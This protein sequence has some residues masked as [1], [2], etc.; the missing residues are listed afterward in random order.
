MSSTIDRVRGVSGVAVVLIS[1]HAAPAHALLFEEHDHGGHRILL[2]RDC[3]SFVGDW[4]KRGDSF[5][6]RCEPWQQTFSYR[7]S[8]EARDGRERHYV[9]DPAQ[10]DALLRRN[11]YAEVWLL[12]GG[13][14]LQAG[15]EMGRMFRQ[16]QMTV[17]VPSAGRIQAAVPGARLFRQGYCVSACTVA[18]MGGLFRLVDE[19]AT[20]EVHSAST[21]QQD[22]PAATR[23]LLV[24]GDFAGIARNARLQARFRALQL[25][26]HFQNTLVTPLRVAPR[27]ENDD[28]FFRW[29]RNFPLPIPYTAA[30]AALD[31]QRIASEGAAAAQDIIM[32]IERDAM[33][34]AIGDLRAAIP[35]LGPRAGAALRMLEAMYDVSIKEQAVLTRE[36]MLRMGYI[37]EEIPLVGRN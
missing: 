26:T 10:L 17:R 7:G 31:R 15:V 24:Q 1:V 29:A 11:Q 2:V 8:Y 28:E 19:G 4:E 35:Q 9:G 36:T 37:T 5:V 16:R 21:V 20:Y 27:R 30:Q 14:S 34:W 22:L 3:G 13:G 23:E 12:S 18:F 33:Q 6:P 25:L 32:R